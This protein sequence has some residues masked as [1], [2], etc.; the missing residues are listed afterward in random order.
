[1]HKSSIEAEQLR[2]CVRTD[3]TASRPLNPQPTSQDAEG[4]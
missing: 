3:N 4:I 1:M 2:Y